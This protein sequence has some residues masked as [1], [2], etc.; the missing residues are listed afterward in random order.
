MPHANIQYCQMGHDKREWV[1]R[2]SYDKLFDII[3]QND[4]RMAFEASGKTI[5]EIAKKAPDVL[6]KLKKLIKTGKIEAVGSPY[7]HVNIVNVDPE[8]CLHSLIEAR[9]AWEHHLDVS[10]TAGWSPECGWIHYL[11]DIYKEAGYKTLILDADSFLLSFKEIREAT[12]LKFDVSGH[13]NKNHLFLIEEYIK[14]K[15]DFL[16]HLTNPGKTDNGLNIIFRSDMM[17]NLMLWYLMGATEGYRKEPVSKDEVREMMRRWK[18]YA[19]KTGSFIMPYAEDAEYIGTTAYFYVKQFGQARFFEHAP[20]SVD[21][22]HDLLKIAVEEGFELST[23]RA[24]LDESDTRINNPFLKYIENGVAWHGGTARAWANTYFSRILD[25]VCKSVFDGIKAV[26]EYLGE[27]LFTMDEML[28]EA[29]RN[30]TVAYVSDA[31]WPP[32][33]TSPGRFDVE[34]ALNGLYQANKLIGK[35]MK[36]NNMEQVRALY[37][38][39]LM[40]TQID[41]IYRE[42]MDYEYFGETLKQKV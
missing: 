19:S 30:V 39:E 42:L 34:D 35:S 20:E 12:G 24:V 37:S 13:S 16:K 41:F 15:P 4:Y 10:P 9:K 23:P 7:I 11:P 40:Q 14:D 29:L 26:A 5:D 2:N 1:I 25:P 36:S 32:E 38:P 33:P 22:F 6:S 21:R 18:E 3:D 27:D 31:R 8:I 17:S 28:K